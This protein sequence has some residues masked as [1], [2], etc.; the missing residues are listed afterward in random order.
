MTAVSE[1]MF[2]LKPETANDIGG[3]I[4]SLVALPQGKILMADISYSKVEMIDLKSPNK[5][6]ASLELDDD[7]WCL[8]ALS[9]TDVAVTT[10]HSRKCIYTLN[11]GNKDIR[12]VSKVETQRQYWGICASSVDDSLIV[13][14]GG[15]SDDPA[16]MDVI[17]RD[18]KLLRT[19]V[20]KNTLPELSCRVFRCTAGRRVFA[21][22]W[23]H[24]TVITVDIN[25]GVLLDNLK[26]Q[27]GNEPYQI[28]LDN[29]DNRFIA[30]EHWFKVLVRSPTGELKDLCMQGEVIDKKFY[31]YPRGVCVTADGTLVVAWYSS[32]AEESVVVGYQFK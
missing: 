22:Q 3:N 13:S 2:M 23:Y 21:S 14:C 29:Q 12:L 19:I 9:S 5:V 7:P 20:D 31:M 4:N 32:R 17:S 16:S 27:D 26:L 11:V 25:D 10:A 28:C 24:G 6:T 8:A 1:K 30:C 18:G 15:A